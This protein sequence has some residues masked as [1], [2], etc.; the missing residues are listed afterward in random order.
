MSVVDTT[1]GFKAIL[2]S[3]NGSLTQL[4]F[5]MSQT[6]EPPH[7]KTNKLTMRPAKTQIS[8]GIRPDLSESSLSAWRNLGL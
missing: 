7:D 4:E 1:G 2:L 5:L 6:Y 8:L 3:H